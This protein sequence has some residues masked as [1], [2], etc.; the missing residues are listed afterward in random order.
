MTIDYQ[1]GALLIN[2]PALRVTIEVATLF[3]FRTPTLPPVSKVGGSFK[4]YLFSKFSSTT[5]SSPVITKVLYNVVT[6][7]LSLQKYHISMPKPA[8]CKIK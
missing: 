3:Q 6:I 2:V 5:E 8:V 7:A 4:D 1:G